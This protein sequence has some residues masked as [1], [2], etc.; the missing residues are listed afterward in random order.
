MSDL[1]IY[2]G[3][4]W[5]HTLTVT[6]ESDGLPR[7]LTG[8]AIVFTALRRGVGGAPQISLSVG[9]GITLLTQSGATL[10]Q[11]TVRIEGAASALL[12][13]GMYTYAVRVTPQGEITP[14]IAIRPTAIAVREYP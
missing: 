1:T 11:A 4:T 9:S 6:K 7:D 13:A 8:A 10:G 5:E 12:A 3:V 2:K 14:Q